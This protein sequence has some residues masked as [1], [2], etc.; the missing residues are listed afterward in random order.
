MDNNTNFYLSGL[1]SFSLFILVFLLFAILLFDSQ[2]SKKFALK[3]DDF[4]SISLI[5]TKVPIPIIK[6]QKSTPIVNEADSSENKEVDINNLFSDVWTKKIIHKKEETKPQD[7]KRL[8][9]IQKKIKAS[10]VNSVKS[11]AQKVNNTKSDKKTEQIS[12]ADEVNEYLAKIQAIVYEYFN[13]PPNSEG[14]SVKTVIELDA[15]GKVLDFRVLNY[16]N[17]TA[18]NAEADKIRERL[19]YVTFPKNPQKKSSRTIVILISE[20]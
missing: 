2:S 4:I 6:K 11:I 5:S 7:T 13:V 1:I 20:E 10:K 3:K 12:T 19:M 14:S 18:L 15:L 9:A 17:N 16:S 8:L